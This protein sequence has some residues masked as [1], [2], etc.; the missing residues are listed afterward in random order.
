MTRE[1]F[2]VAKADSLQKHSKRGR[3]WAGRSPRLGWLRLASSSL[4]PLWR[5]PAPVTQTKAHITRLCPRKASWV[6]KRFH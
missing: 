2:Q 3:G 1:M 5:P 4:L 6:G